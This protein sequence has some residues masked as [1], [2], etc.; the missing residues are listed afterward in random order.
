MA[1]RDT[2]SPAPLAPC[3]T[4]APCDGGRSKSS[5]VK[6][7]RTVSR[8]F[9]AVAATADVV[10]DAPIKVRVG[11]KDI[12]L[13][14]LDGEFFAIDNICTHGAAQLSD[15]YVEG[16]LIECPQHGG[17]FEIRTGKAAGYPCVVDVE[18]YP[19]K[20]ENG[21]IEVGIDS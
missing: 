1:A 6:N 11:D 4:R 5:T 21:T 13:F 17:S 3:A 8:E 14:N 19:V 18:S 15:G 2:G 12:A 7:P 9:H 16:E 10:A 20:V